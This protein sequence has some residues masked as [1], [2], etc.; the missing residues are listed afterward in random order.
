MSEA[1]ARG[2]LKEGGK[3]S[4]F[5]SPPE[6]VGEAFLFVLEERQPSFAGIGFEALKN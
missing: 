1:F 2:R 6:D 3:G 5:T 4:S